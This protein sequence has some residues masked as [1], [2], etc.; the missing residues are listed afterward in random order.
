MIKKDCCIKGYK[1]IL[2]TDGYAFECFLY[3]KGKRTAIVL[4]GGYGGCNDYQVLDE[5]LY[6]EFSDFV[7]KLGNVIPKTE[8]DIKFQEKYGPIKYDDDIFI[9]DLIAEFET[10][11]FYRTKCRKHTLVKL[12][13]HKE[14]EFLQFNSPYNPTMKI[15]VMQK[16]P[17]A[18]IINETV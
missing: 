10:Q 4:N 3:V 2:S 18:V 13:N 6:K 7:K 8:I 5:N 1:T 15:Y 9:G 12:P 14:D 11:K 16:Y 17:D